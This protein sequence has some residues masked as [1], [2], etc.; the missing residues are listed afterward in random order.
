MIRHRHLWHLRAAALAAG[1]GLLARRGPASAGARGDC[2]RARRS[3][4]ET[5]G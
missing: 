2:A 1:L 4:S 5:G 3:A